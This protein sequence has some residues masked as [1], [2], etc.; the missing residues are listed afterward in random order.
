M[1]STVSS[2]T[3]YST[4]TETIDIN[5]TKQQAVRRATGSL[6]TDYSHRIFTLAAD[7]T[8]TLLTLGASNAGGQVSASDIHYI[9]VSNLDDETAVRLVINMVT[10][11]PADAGSFHVS[12]NPGASYLISVKQAA[13]VAAGAAFAAYNTISTIQAVTA[14]GST[15]DVELFLISK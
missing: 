9:R 1:A 5:G 10:A 15:I 12:L 13:I 4:L 14:A 7:A 3:F 6:V 2:T 11:A 8:S